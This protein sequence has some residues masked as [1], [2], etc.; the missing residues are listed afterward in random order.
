[1]R[2]ALGYTATLFV[3]S[4]FRPPWSR[5]GPVSRHMTVPPFRFILVP[6]NWCP[7]ATQGVKTCYCRYLK[8]RNGIQV[9][10]GKH[11]YNSKKIII[12]MQQMIAVTSCPGR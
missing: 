8:C 11:K 12:D 4:P 10:S 1:M 7:C 2:E 6:Y 3:R 5:S 9:A